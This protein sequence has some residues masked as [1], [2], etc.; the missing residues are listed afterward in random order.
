MFKKGHKVVR[1]KPPTIDFNVPGLSKD[2]LI[3]ND[4]VS[5]APK[6]YQNRYMAVLTSGKSKT[7]A[8]S[9]K[10]HECCGF[11]DSTNRVKNCTVRSCPLWMVR[12]G[13]KVK[14]EVPN[15]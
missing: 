7:K 10:C 4:I 8:I 11:E 15:V 3:I 14:N 2:T 1:K 12:P 9:M 5:R 13:G 6:S